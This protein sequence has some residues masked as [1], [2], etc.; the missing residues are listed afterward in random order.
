[1]KR[2]PLRVTAVICIIVLAAGIGF[3]YDRIS[4]AIEKNIYPLKY[5]EYVEKYSEK[6]GVPQNIIY[7]TIKVESDFNS[8]AVSSA[9]AIGLMQIMPST[10][11]WL[12]GMIGENLDIMALYDPDTNIK[13]GTY[14]LIY[15]YNRYGDWTLA[16]MA[17]N[18]GIGNVSE[19]LENEDYIDGD[20]KIVNIPF[21]ETRNYIKKIEKTLGRY[22][23]I[24]AR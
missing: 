15:L 4:S 20:G 18:A 10:F 1:M 7:S 22:N 23:K 5:S 21:K 11:E 3:A 8:D 19:W 9:G 17:Y 2:T 14:Y 12:Q 16:H 13:Y 6:Y 24:Y